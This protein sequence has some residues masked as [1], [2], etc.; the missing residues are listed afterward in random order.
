MCFIVNVD[1]LKL[2]EP[3]IIVDQEENVHV[4]FVDD[5][6]PKYL[7]ELQKD[8]ILNERV[9]TSRSGYVEYIHVDIK[10]MHPNNNYG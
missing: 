10:G 9:W 5:F 7:N 2:Y 6:A 3:L 8:I 1:N 4:P